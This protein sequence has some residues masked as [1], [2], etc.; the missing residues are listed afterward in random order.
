MKQY[1]CIFLFL[2]LVS[3]KTFL[4]QSEFSLRGYLLLDSTSGDLDKDKLPE[5]VVAY[6]LE[7]TG[8]ALPP[9]PERLVH[10]YKKQNGQWI[11]WLQSAEA[12]LHKEDGGITGDPY[13]AIY[14]KSGVLYIEHFGG[15]S[16]K[17]HT[18]DTYKFYRHQFRLIGTFSYYGKCCEYW[19]STDFNLISGKINYAKSCDYGEN[20]ESEKCANQKETHSRKGIFITFENRREKK[21]EITLPKYKEVLYL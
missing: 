18:I 14:I 3:C 15:S 5:L 13:S 16:W 2:F 19:V 17:W 1:R 4:A 11:L 20:Y 10:V 9:K 6:T 12:L 8:D 21:Y 7:E